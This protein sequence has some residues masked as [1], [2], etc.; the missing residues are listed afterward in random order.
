MAIESLLAGHAGED[1]EFAEDDDVGV[2]DLAVVDHVGV[3]TV[4]GCATFDVED[5]VG[6]VFGAGSIFESDQKL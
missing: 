1:A 4:F 2:C 6:F 5:D 3:A